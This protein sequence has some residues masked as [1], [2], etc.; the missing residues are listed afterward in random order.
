ML[1]ISVLFFDKNIY[2]SFIAILR[3]YHL[4]LDCK[5]SKTTHVTLIILFGIVL[6]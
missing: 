6:I 4:L 5:N 1:E 2:L 3:L